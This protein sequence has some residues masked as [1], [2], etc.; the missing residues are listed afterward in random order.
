M[1]DN[2]WNYRNSHSG[3]SSGPHGLC[4]KI[5]GNDHERELCESQIGADLL[6]QAHNTS[7]VVDGEERA[8]ALKTVPHLIHTGRQ[9]LG[10]SVF[11]SSCSKHVR[12][13][14]ILTYS[15]IQRTLF[16]HHHHSY[17]QQCCIIR[18]TGLR[19]HHN[20]WYNVKVRTNTAQST[21]S[22]PPR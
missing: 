9:G 15:C 6:C 12:W 19:L 4:S 10:C 8:V 7:G 13:V 18:M 1:S 11:H 14:S 21:W 5:P 2:G 20:V 17:V 3:C 22:C 16:K